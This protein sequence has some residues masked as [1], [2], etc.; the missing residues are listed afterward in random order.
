MTRN[1]FAV[2]P[3]VQCLPHMQAIV[4]LQTRKRHNDKIH[5]QQK[6]A[7]LRNN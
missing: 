2:R 3:R 7:T 5:S 1:N 4:F 6:A